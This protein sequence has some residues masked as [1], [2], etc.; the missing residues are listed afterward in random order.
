MD[1]CLHI[2]AHR[3]GTTT[4]QQFMYNN[5]RVLRDHGT[6]FW[7]PRQTRDGLFAGLVKDPVFL[8]PADERLW[9]RSIGRIKIALSRAQAERARHLVISE[10]NMIGTMAEN[11]RSS[12]LYSQ[13][14]ERM[15]RFAPAFAGNKVKI[16]IAIRSYERHWASALSFRIR[17]GMRVPG[18][19]SLD[20]MVTQPRR[21]QHLIIDVAQAFPQAQIMVWPFE[22][23]GSQPESQLAAI[24]GRPVPMGARTT[25][26]WCN[27]SRD[28]QEL[29]VCLSDR[30]DHEG[31]AQMR[32]HGDH[33]MPFNADHIA[34][35]KQDYSA[36]ISWLT[37]G[38]DG[39]ATYLGP[40]GETFGGPTD[41]RG[42][43]HERPK[44]RLVGTG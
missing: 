41:T 13:A 10:E 18:A 32:T 33:Y 44:E 20:M 9:S 38:A 25:N 42:R 24:T 1:I 17:S 34:K 36:D 21:W 6:R 8:S 14:G 40:T 5:D 23:W 43:R 3:T 16:G 27:P 7:G 4:F 37:S 29:A 26:P 39:L 22:A 12:M 30:G 35:L 11:F 28:P 2:G 19:E 15:A 31:A